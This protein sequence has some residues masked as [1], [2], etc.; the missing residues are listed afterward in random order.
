VLQSSEL[1]AF[2]AT[3]D[4]GRA[5]GFYGGILGLPLVSQSPIAC[6]F[7][8]HQG[9]IRVT[10]V[11]RVVQAPYTVLGWVVSDLVSTIGELAQR[12][13]EFLRYEGIDQ[14]QRGVWSTP[15]GAQVAWFKD[16]DGN[17]LSL[18]QL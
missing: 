16:P 7:Q 12:G 3:T 10:V 11:E 2:V 17:T 4:V 5:R 6:V 9:V 14:D 13:V 8:A 15:G 1:V 18:T